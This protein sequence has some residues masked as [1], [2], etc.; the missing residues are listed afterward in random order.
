MYQ[1]R[2][3]IDKIEYES[4][5]QG[6]TMAN[7]LQSA[8]WSN[9]KSEWEAEYTAVY[10]EDTMIGC[11]LIL[12]RSIKGIK[13]G[14]MPRGPILDYE[15]E[16]LLEFYIKAIRN[17]AKEKKLIFVKV[18]PK[19]ILKE[20]FVKD[21]D[22]TLETELGKKVI[23]I[24]EKNK[25]KYH[26]R[27]IMM[28][29]TFQPRFDAVT[30]LKENIIDS[31]SKVAKK[32]VRRAEERGIEIV[33]ASHR[34]LD[35]FMELLQKTMDRQ[36]I[37]LRNKEYFEKLWENYEEHIT[38]G[39]AKI[40]VA[41]CTDIALENIEKLKEKTQVVKK[42][43]LA[44]LDNR[45]DRLNKDIE[46]L[47]SLEVED[48]YMSAMF[49][50]GY[51]ETFEML[52]AGMDE[53][54]KDFFPQYLLYEAMMKKAYEKGMKQACIGGVEGTLKDGL[55]KSKEHFGAK[56]V[57]YIGEFDIVASPIYYLFNLA[58]KFR[59]ALKKRKK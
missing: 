40:N 54:F 55:T 8:N 4:F 35:V 28:S 26:G 38:F 11:G 15:N 34:E 42:G 14:Y 25:A 51:G 27:T 57:S 48:V 53:T 17:F 22:N 19:V 33:W 6:H 50:I 18:D 47:E 5:A 46:L 13:F 7:L 9:I 41:K 59:A 52:Y 3:N 24:F 36:N 44:Q 45:I 58:W 2:N 12:I 37:N 16:E 29:D 30:P 20:A 56:I 31:Y 49:A 23:S 1:F 39:M 21:F 43:L 10:E 32:R